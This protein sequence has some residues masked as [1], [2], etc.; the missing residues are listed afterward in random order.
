MFAEFKHKLTS[1]IIAVLVRI[2]I[3]CT[4]NGTE[5]TT[6]C[7]ARFLATVLRLLYFPGV[8]LL[9]GNLKTVF[10]EKD[11][12]QINEMMKSNLFHTVWNW[13]DF[14][15]IIHKPELVEQMVDEVI[16]P[17]GL[18]PQMILC[19]PHLGNW[20][21]LAQYLPKYYKNSAAVA[22]SFP[23]KSLN[24]MLEKSRSMNGL[25]IIPRN[26]AARHIISAIHK[27]TSIGILIDQNLSPKHGGIFVDF[28]KLPVPT[29]PLPAIL[30]EK[31]GVQ[32]LTGSCIRK[33]NGK[34]KLVISIIDTAGLQGRHDI[35]QAIM[36]ANERLILEYP[37]QYTW[38]YRR[39]FYIPADLEE[40]RKRLFP[41]YARQKKYTLAA[42]S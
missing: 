4:G 28:C 30:A 17:S 24:D 22:E 27:G 41:Y 11:A 20:E 19:L 6:R 42:N 29:S 14:I 5:K 21:L 39:W 25:A 38:L 31:Y 37:E 40:A 9:R 7:Q 3:L 32:L 2:V 16:M 26:G 12:R 15:R 34:F 33:D 10:P 23:Y 13:L 1:L 8:K 18:A 35:T 36:N